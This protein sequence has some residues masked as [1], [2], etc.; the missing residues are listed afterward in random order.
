MLDLIEDDNSSGEPFRFRIA[1]ISPTPSNDIVAAVT[2][3]LN[4]AWPQPVTIASAVP[5]GDVNW[6]FGERRWRDRQ[7]PRQTWGRT[8]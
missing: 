1:D 5:P 3:A 6:R 4:E 8:G 7:I 2:A